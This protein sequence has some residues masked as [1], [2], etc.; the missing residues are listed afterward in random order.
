MKPIVKL[1]EQ[2]ETHELGRY[3]KSFGLS[4]AITSLFSAL[5][6]IVK[7]T[8]QSTVLAMMTAATGHHWI[9]HGILDLLVFF[10]LGWL[11]A[12]SHNGQGVSITGRSLIVCIVASLVISWMIIAGFYIAE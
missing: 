8:S 7:E 6:V 10:F 3:T 4:F 11:L 2:V 5:L 9:T 12:Q 1:D